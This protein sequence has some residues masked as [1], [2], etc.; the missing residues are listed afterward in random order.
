MTG[1]CL[2]IHAHSQLHSEKVRMQSFVKQRY[3]LVQLQDA[4][5][6]ERVLFY[7]QSHY[8]TLLLNL[9]SKQLGEQYEISSRQIL[10]IISFSDIKKKAY[11]QV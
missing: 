1:L 4:Y 2:L 3:Q 10:K 6:H 7:F 5:L 9:P 11:T 8:Y